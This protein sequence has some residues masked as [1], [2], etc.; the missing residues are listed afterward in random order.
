MVAT[1]IYTDMLLMLQEL[2]KAYEFSF[3]T[4]RILLPAWIQT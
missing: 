2:G 1:R 3:I 4:N